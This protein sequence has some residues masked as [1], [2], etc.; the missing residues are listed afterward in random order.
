MRTWLQ[1]LRYAVRG[2]VK[3]P[4]FTAVA[5]L[6]LGLGIGAN[7]AIFSLLD[8]A[9]FQRLPVEHP[10]ELRTTIVVSRKGETM[11]NVPSELFQEL[12]RAPRAFSG[13][14]AYWQTEMNLDTGGDADRVLVQYVSGRYYSTLGVPI[15]LG[16][17]I[18]DARRPAR[19]CVLIEHQSPATRRRYHA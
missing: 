5:M 2:L 14:I 19:K 16:R 7:T 1:D 10:E 18:V 9:L 12:R 13:V 4:G 11:S 15:F 8:E 6:T 17:P 3:A